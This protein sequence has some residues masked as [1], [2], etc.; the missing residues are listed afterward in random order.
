MKAHYLYAVED[1]IARMKKDSKRIYGRIIPQALLT[2]NK[3]GGD[4]DSNPE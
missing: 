1:G 3:L 2:R 4:G